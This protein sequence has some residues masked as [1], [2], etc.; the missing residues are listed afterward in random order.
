MGAHRA[1]G[2]SRS[3]PLLTPMISP[4]TGFLGLVLL[5]LAA[6]LVRQYATGVSLRN[7][8]A[9]DRAVHDDLV[10]QL[11]KIPPAART[12]ASSAT[13]ARV[14][15]NTPAEFARPDP[16]PAASAQPLARTAPWKNAGRANPAAALET[17]MWA[18]TNGDVDFLSQMIAIDPEAQASAVRLFAT[19]PD[20]FRAEYPTPERLSALMLAHDAPLGGI[21]ILEQTEPSAG[22]ALLRV[23]MK[24]LD[25]ASKETDLA[26]INHAGAWQLVITRGLIERFGKKLAASPTGAPAR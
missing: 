26:F 6:I 11:E 22:Q 20:K 2:R 14:N 9:L 13:S 10:G 4:R 17:A 8:I 5:I 16:A 25:G 23:R 7:E 12:P 18:A 1:N 21:D 15:P 3:Q 24:R 19:L